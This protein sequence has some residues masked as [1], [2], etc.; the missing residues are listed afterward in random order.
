MLYKDLKLGGDVASYNKANELLSFYVKTGKLTEK[1]E[2]FTINVAAITASSANIEMS[3]E[4]TSV[5]FGIVADIDATI[6]T[7]IENS[8]NKDNR[9][10]YQAA[11]YYYENGKD[12]NTALTWVNKATEQYPKAYWIM[13]LKAKIENKLNDTAAAIV[14]ANKVIAMATEGKNADYVKMGEDLI[15]TIRKPATI[16]PATEPKKKK[17]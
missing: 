9:P 17:K 6:M 2:T 3:W 7:N 16:A 5:S 8:V 13:L 1:V 11:T 10:Y 14:S 15:K 12:L 4:N